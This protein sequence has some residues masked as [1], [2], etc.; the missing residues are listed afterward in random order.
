MSKRKTRS[1][2]H[3]AAVA[4]ARA[5]AGTPERVE[6]APSKRARGAVDVMAG[7][8][9]L[10][11]PGL[12]VRFVLIGGLVLLSISQ[13]LTS[14][15][16]PAAVQAAGVLGGL[17][18]LFFVGT[19]MVRHYRALYRIRRDQPGAWQPTM[20]FAFASLA[21]PLGFSGPAASPRDRTLRRVTFVLVLIYLA[22]ALI[23]L[24]RPH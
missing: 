17:C 3:R 13:G 18:V 1:Q 12:I 8:R 22:T 9:E 23:A 16:P 4:R 24:S 19:G 5:E 7:Y 11:S 10:A 6:P 2:R 14:K 20:S 15:N 21:V